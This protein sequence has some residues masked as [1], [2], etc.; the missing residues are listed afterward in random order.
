MVVTSAAVILSFC[1]ELKSDQPRKPQVHQQLLWGDHSL[2]A[3]SHREC[4][5]SQCRRQLHSYPSFFNLLQSGEQLKASLYI[6]PHLTEYSGIYCS[7][8]IKSVLTCFGSLHYQSVQ[9]QLDS[10]QYSATVKQEIPRHCKA[11]QG[12][13]G[14]CTDG[15]LEPTEQ[16]CSTQDCLMFVYSIYAV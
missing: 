1:P 13:E 16:L 3:Q 6:Q 12:S 10:R 5:T 9:H 4:N 7:L 2:C 15:V 14:K 11:V 8:K